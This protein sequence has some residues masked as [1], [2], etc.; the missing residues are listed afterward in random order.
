MT[1]FKQIIKPS[2]FQRIDLG[3]QLVKKDKMIIDYLRLIID[4]GLLDW[5]LWWIGRIVFLSVVLIIGLMSLV[6]SVGRKDLLDYLYIW[7]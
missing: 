1:F 6:D 7:Q 4:G 3:N 2:I 5:T